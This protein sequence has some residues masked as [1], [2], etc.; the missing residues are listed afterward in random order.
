[1]GSNWAV[2]ACSWK[3]LGVVWSELGAR[4]TG[5]LLDKAPAVSSLSMFDFLLPFCPSCKGRHCCSMLGYVQKGW[6][7]W[8]QPHYAE[9]G[10]DKPY[11]PNE[12]VKW[13]IYQLP[14]TVQPQ[15]FPSVLLQH[16]A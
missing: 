14:T 1:M 16:S 8:V 6:L 10:S 2:H 9:Y 7:V 15:S 3:R 5:A 11:I 13:R 4:A 12:A